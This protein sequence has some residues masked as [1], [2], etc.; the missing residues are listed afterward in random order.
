MR[1]T[2]N[3]KCLGHKTLE[4]QYRIA[5]G[6]ACVPPA[7]PALHNTKLLVFDFFAFFLTW[8]LQVGTYLSLNVSFQQNE[9]NCSLWL[10]RDS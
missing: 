10:M 2:R 7:A 4:R 5:L 6:I 8:L 9:V 3:L 1:Y